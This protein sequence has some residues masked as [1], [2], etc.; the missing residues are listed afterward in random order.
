MAE[1][2]SRATETSAST[3]NRST[4][5]LD[6]PP[7]VTST[8]ESSLLCHWD[9]LPEWQRDN[10]YIHNGYVRETN[11]LK[12][13]LHSL[14]YLHNETVNIYSHLVPSATVLTVLS[15]TGLAVLIAS[16]FSVIFPKIP[17]FFPD[18]S[19]FFSIYQT[20]GW[21]DALAAIIFLAGVATCLGLS[22]AFHTL[23]SHSQVIATFGN[24][25]DYLGI[26]VLIVASMVTLIHYSFI[27]QPPMMRIFFW[28]LTAILG[29]MCAVVSLSPTFRTPEW[30]AVRASM[31]VA[32]GLSGTLPVLTSLYLFGIELT[33]V[34][35]SLGWLLL[36]A[37]LYI[38]GAVIYAA[39]IPEA[40]H[41]GKYDYFGH[42]HQIFHVFVVL[43]AICHGLCLYHSYEYAHTYVMQ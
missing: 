26:V 4:V 18:L 32:F 12:K 38:G 29:T 1:T 6:L 33:W 15:F 41:P 24:K 37:V 39:R 7:S 13:C 20:T 34:R 28:S 5:P 40:F 27:D 10:H 2:S 19:P 8:L 23:K 42:S 21:S 43:A 30:R 35:M 16:A 9:L 3:I 14:T 11:S 36:E 25:L 31:F 22:A 17:S